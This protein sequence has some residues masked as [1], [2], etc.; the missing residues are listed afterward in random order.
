MHAACANLDDFAT[1][2]AVTLTAVAAPGSVFT[3]WLG[4]CTG[5]QAC[6]VNVNG[7]T[8]VS[9]TFAPN[10]VLPGIDI[11]GNG[12]Y[13]ALTDGLLILRY[14]LDL[15]G[16]A[17]T[18]GATVAGAPRTTPVEVSLQL[19]N[20]KPLVDVDGNGQCDALTDGLIL[21]RYL[22]GLRGNPLIAGAVGAGATRVTALQI[23]D[24]IRSITPP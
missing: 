21:I 5:T 14:L 11:D 23:E 9:A 20:I 7:A 24:Y 3:G 15:T 18:N 10:T 4:G 19:A 17:L 16:T 1:G 6:V 12:A 13:A 2:T 22:F 8:G